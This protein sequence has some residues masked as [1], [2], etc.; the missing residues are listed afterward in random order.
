MV[1]NILRAIRYEGPFICDKCYN[2]LYD[3]MHH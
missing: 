2:S 1:R 3:A